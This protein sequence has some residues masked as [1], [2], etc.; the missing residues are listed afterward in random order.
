[1]SNPPYSGCSSPISAT[2]H[3]ILI[4]KNGKVERERERVHPVYVVHVV[5]ILTF[6]LLMPLS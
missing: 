2:R 6:T 1:M 4:Y 3:G 5:Q